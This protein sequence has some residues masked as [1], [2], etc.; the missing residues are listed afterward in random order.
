MKKRK[1]IIT[2]VL[3]IILTGVLSWTVIKGLGAGGTGAMKNIKTGL[4]LSGGV[5]ITYEAAEE[6]PSAEA[7]SDTVYKLQQRVD[8]YSTEAQVYKQGSNRISVEIPGVSDANKILEELGKPGALEFQDESGKVVL[9]GT[10][11]AGAEGVST[12]DQSSGQRQ[13]LV[14]L[15]MTKEGAK[16][17]EEVTGANVGKRISIIYDGKVV[18]SPTVRQKISGGSAQIDGMESLEEAKNLASFIRIG[19]L[20]LKLNEVY[21][22]VVGAQLGQDALTTSVKAGIIGLVLVI[23]LMI[24]LFRVSGIV[25][26]WAL[27]LFALIDLL[28]INAFDVTLTLPGIAGVILTIGMAVDANVIIYTR[29]K[30]ELANGVSVKTAVRSGFHK[31][32]S[33]ILDGNVTTL[34]AAAV[35]GTLGTGTIKGFAITLAM[36]IIFSMFTALVIARILSYTFV[37]LGAT[38]VSLYGTKKAR[39]PFRLIEKKAFFFVLSIILIV[40]GPIGMAV[41]NSSKGS[42]LNFSLDFIGGTATTVDF[43]KDIS[44]ADLNKEV[45]PIVQKVTGDAN[46]QFQKVTD[47]DQVIIKTRELSVDE[48]QKL[49]DSIHNSYKEV[50]NDGITAENISATM[51]NEMRTNAVRAVVIALILML[52]YIWFRFRDPRFAVGAIIALAHDIAIIFMFYVW[53]RF[54]VGSSFVA[55]MLTILGYSVNDT[56]VVFD[57]IREEYHGKGS[58]RQVVNQAITDTMSR[59]ILTSVTT[60]ITIFIL[61][62]LGVPSVKEFS[63]P[64]IIGIIAGTYSSIFIASPL[65]YVMKTRLGKKRIQDV[66]PAYESAEEQ[67]SETDADTG[68]TMGEAKKKAVSA[69]K[70]K[71]R[72]ELQSIKPKR[73]RRRR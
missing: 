17:F 56:I 40:L 72:S 10:D 69:K 53:S 23:L 45:Q 62:I 2:L 8:Q 12:T 9:K 37:N 49:N 6:N 18:S 44:L 52:L 48:R 14:E 32:F 50:K 63:L 24:V 70:K 28:A 65:W 25:A 66:A 21:S 58:V 11:I 13:Y 59:S 30:E 42:P 41:Q 5:S 1:S 3:M 20:S 34:I 51:S 4:D 61:Y 67:A 33:A 26:G 29:M 39:K 46:I 38:R 22:N 36:G 68:D 15:T 47:S 43:G 60:F 27:Y 71:D 57:R 55:V 35:L 7:M 19:S 16:T 64:I 73:G 54:S 31:A